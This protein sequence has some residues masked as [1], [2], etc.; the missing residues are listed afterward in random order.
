[1]HRFVALAAAAMSLAFIAAPASADLGPG[2]TAPPIKVAKWFKG[3][4]VETFEP[5]KVYVV[6]FWATWCGPCRVSIPHLTELSHKYRG[7]VTF[8]GISVW[9]RGENVL[10]G[11]QKFVDEMGDKMDYAVAADEAGGTMARTWMTAANQNGIP[12]AFIVDGAGKIAWIGHPMS[13]L[14]STLDKVLAG[15]WNAAAYRAAF[16][17]Q[18]TAEEL[19]DRLGGLYRS[20][21][22]AEALK[23]LDAAVAKDRALEEPCAPARIALLQKID[24]QRAQAYA[25][26]AAQTFLRGNANA[27][28]QLAWM[29]V[30]PGSSF[31]KPN[32]A[33]A[34]QIARLAAA[35]S[36]DDPNVLDTLAL[37]Q[38]RSGQ[39][40]AAIATQKRAIE[41]AKRKGVDAQNL[42]EM[43]GRLRQ[44]QSGK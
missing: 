29:I 25:L 22:Y 11:V 14:D 44:F 39:K 9:E 26:K 33:I 2:D 21:K 7:K 30:M 31:K 8:A 28:N 40:A 27:L 18:R 1:M 10:E 41:L 43:E 23:Q 37:A 35:A 34:L 36:K 13:D 17:R 15:T 19:M 6:E 3:T 4:P 38:Y 24:E 20:G 12:C 16:D 42:K 32:Y 5:G